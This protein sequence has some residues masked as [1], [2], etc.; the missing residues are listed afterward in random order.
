ML[1]GK[2]GQLWSALEPVLAGAGYELVDLDW[3]FSTTQGG[4]NTLRL[5]IDTTDPETKVGIEDCENASNVIG[6][7][8]DEADLIDSRYVLEVSSPGMERRMR[9]EKDFQRFIGRE[10]QVDLTEKH[11]GRR[12]IKGTILG[13]ADGTVTLRPVE[14]GEFSFPLEILKRAQLVVDFDRLFQNLAKEEKP[15]RS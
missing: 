7:F 10:V 8:L 6:L 5:F 3:V 14:G 13:A 11:D 15:H 12:R 1:A 2:A 4:E 9:R